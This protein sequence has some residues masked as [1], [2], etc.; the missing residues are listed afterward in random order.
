MFK[1]F[2]K[3]QTNFDDYL[4]DREFECVELTEV[5]NE[6]LNMDASHRYNTSTSDGHNKIKINK[7]TF[8]WMENTPE[9]YRMVVGPINIYWRSI[10]VTEESALKFELGSILKPN[11]TFVR[12][13]CSNVTWR[14]WYYTALPKHLSQIKFGQE[15]FRYSDFRSADKNPLGVVIS[16]IY[17]MWPFGKL[18][19][20]NKLTEIYRPS[21][22]IIVPKDKYANLV[23]D[24]KTWML[25]S[26]EE[27]DY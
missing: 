7:N 14:Q 1:C 2:T 26:G 25:E 18:I 27:Y 10:L 20:D 23:R 11:T 4:L 15:I 17:P 13:C 24:D 12:H 5:E 6:K 3:P 9:G 8:V 16:M 19:M 21:N 22:V